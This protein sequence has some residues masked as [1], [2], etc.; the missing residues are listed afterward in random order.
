ME[1][2]NERQRAEYQ[3]ALDKIE[4]DLRA[5]EKAHASAEGKDDEKQP[6]DA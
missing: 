4:A 6:E 1:A 2:A 5:I 3:Q